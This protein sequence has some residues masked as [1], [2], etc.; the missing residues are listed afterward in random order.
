MAGANDQG[1]LLM[2]GTATRKPPENKLSCVRDRFLFST[3]AFKARN[4]FIMTQ[5]P[6]K[7]TIEDFW[8]IVLQYK[9]GTV[10]MLNDLQEGEEV[11]DVWLQRV[12]LFYMHMAGN[13]SNLK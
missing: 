2:P 5:A 11:K 13:V 9:I 3:Q 4:A 10:V 8:Q 12:C 1:N 6:L 7:S